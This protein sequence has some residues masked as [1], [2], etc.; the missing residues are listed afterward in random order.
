M[1]AG[2]KTLE[3][4]SS[5][6]FYEKLKEKSDA[7]W[8]GFRQNSKSLGI[9]YAFNTIESLSCTFFTEGKVESYAEAVKSDTKK[10]AA[11][12]HNMLK[13]G[14]S[15]A[16]AQFEAMFVSSVHTDEDIEKTI[17]AHY[18]SLKEL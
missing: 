9:N 7:L 14:I 11:F 5:N 17:K 15:L 16:P 6:G 10:Y 18:E 4:L 12:F 2:L 8:E 1:T 3:K 13:H